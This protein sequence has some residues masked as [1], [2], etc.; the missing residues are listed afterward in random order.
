MLSGNSKR[1]VVIKDIPSNMVEEA[2]LILKG[3]PG[4]KPGQTTSTAAPKKDKK[5]NDDYLIKEAEMI[6]NNYIRENSSG[7]ARKKGMEAKTHI[8]TQKLWVNIAIN[9]ALFGSIALLIF[10]ISRMA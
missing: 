2:I 9:S 5:G 8:R 1:V 10:L 4:A 6:I 3:E 7:N